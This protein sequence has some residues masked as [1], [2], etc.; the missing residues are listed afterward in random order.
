MCGNPI[1]LTSDEQ[2]VEALERFNSTFP[3]TVQSSVGDLN[4]YA[5]KLCDHAFVYA[6][7]TNGELSGLAVCYANEYSSRTAYLT[8]MAVLSKYQSQ[9]IG[10]YL[11]EFI[12]ALSKQ[13]GME[14]IKLEVAYGNLGAIAFYRNHQF[15]VAGH[16]SIDSQFM[17]RG[18]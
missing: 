17:E 5:R 13:L 6:M 16:A 1:R 15:V 4:A 11:L 18:L 12:C 3:R 2:I 14:T 7:K 10:H 8:R 9:G